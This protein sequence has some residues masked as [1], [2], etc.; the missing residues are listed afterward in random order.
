MVSRAASSVTSG[1]RGTVAGI[2]SNGA[3]WVE[4]IQIA[5]NGAPIT[6]ADTMTWQFNFRQNDQTLSA[7]LSLSTA[8]GTLTIVQGT[9]ETTVQIRVASSLLTNIEGDYIADLAS[10]AVDGTVTHWLHGIV[11]FIKEPVWVS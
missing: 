10:R 4:D 8:T 9:T 1:A 11:T 6:S 5:E 7:A 3:T 2:V